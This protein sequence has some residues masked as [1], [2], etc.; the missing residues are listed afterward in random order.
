M[1][2]NELA[3]LQR[4]PSPH[5]IGKVASMVVA[6]SLVT[7]CAALPESVLERD[8]VSALS[9]PGAF[10]AE[11]SEMVS[12]SESLVVDGLLDLFDDA[13]LDRMVQA[14]IDNNPD[15][16]L[17]AERV[18]EA[19][20]EAGAGWS[21]LFPNL[22]TGVSTDRTKNADAEITGSYSPSLDVSWEVDLWGK[23][24]AQARAG[25]A[26]QAARIEDLQ[27]VRDSIAGQVMQAWFDTVTA[28]HRVRLEKARL[29]NLMM[30]AD[31]NR[32]QFQAGL[33]SLQDLTVV[34][35]DI[36][37]TQATITSDQGQFRHQVRLLQVLMGEYPSAELVST[38]ELPHLIDPPRPGVPASVLTERPDLRA[39]WQMVLA[40]DER[41]TA[42]HR[43]Q[44]PSFSLTSSIG[45]QSTRFSDLLTGASIW[46][47]A[48][49][50]A[51]PI[52]NAGRLESQMMA[53][54][55][56][57]EQAWISYLTISLR[58]FQEVETALDREAVL[59]EQEAH[60]HLAA[61]QAEKTAE[62]FENRYRKGLVSILELLT[63]QNDVFNLQREL[64]GLRNDRLK[65]RVALALAMGMGV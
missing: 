5:E 46:S 6:C 47:L 14:A 23:L 63:A 17:A 9:V 48:T 10:R 19:G 18:E 31:T 60:L 33:L 12:A 1:Q 55:S 61:Q 39:A 62:I 16:W 44:F 40:A 51:F 11:P 56:R 41:V 59:M 45:R 34:E 24:T 49:S 3:G 22:S 35:R 64:L 32:L 52:F 27:A 57:A 7:A 8:P 38:F 20:F 13:E 50:F 36:A 2:F 30:I 53:E 42:A 4:R 58:A 15:V 29:A 54:H 26:T 65:N 37:Q 28:D 43:E 25:D 21:N